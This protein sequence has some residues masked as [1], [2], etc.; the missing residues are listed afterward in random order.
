LSEVILSRVV[1]ALLHCYLRQL[2]QDAQTVFSDGGMGV[3]AC[4]LK[5][6]K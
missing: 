1:A 5:N 6:L 2:L 4:A 3:P